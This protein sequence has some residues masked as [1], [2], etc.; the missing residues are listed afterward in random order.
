MQ[1]FPD[2]EAEL[3]K[4]DPRLSIVPN[5]NYPQLA[6]IKLDGV[7]VCPIPANDIREESD[8]SYTVEFSNGFRSKHRSRPE[9]IDRV[10]AIIEMIKTKEGADIFFNK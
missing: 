5:P 9:A 7:D 8:P 4:I 3:R 6:N 1:V 10:N 2:F